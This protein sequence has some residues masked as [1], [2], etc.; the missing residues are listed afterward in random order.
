MKRRAFTLVELLTVIAIIGV[1]VGLLLPAI[2]AAREAGR[3]TQCA[4]NIKQIALACLQHEEAHRQFP[5]DGW[6]WRWLGDPDRGYGR[7]QTGGW[8]YNVL[9]YIEE[10]AIRRMGSDGQPDV[11][12]PTQMEGITNVCELP[13]PWLNCPSRRNAILYPI[14]ESVNA[15][16]RNVNRV[17]ASPRLDYVANYGDKYP[18][19]D[20]S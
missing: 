9:E 14:L 12:T 1:L 11:I 2:Q 17:T 8:L 6:G 18:I 15:K 3:R 19:Y 4:N 16:F 13:L 5:T 7:N 10:P 20:A